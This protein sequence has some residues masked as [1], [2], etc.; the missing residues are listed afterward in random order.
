MK[1]KVVVLL[2]FDTIVCA[3]APASCLEPLNACESKSWKE[4][5]KL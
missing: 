5:N 4:S 2:H 3:L 1:D